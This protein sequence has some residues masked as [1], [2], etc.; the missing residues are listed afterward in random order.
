[1][2]Q[3]T[4]SSIPYIKGKATNEYFYEMMK[5]NNPI[6]FALGYKENYC[7]RVKYMEIFLNLALTQKQNL[8]QFLTE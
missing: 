7:I 2:K 1:M 6:A 5:L 3:R 8:N 4:E